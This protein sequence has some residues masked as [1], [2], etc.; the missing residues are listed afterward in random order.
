MYRILYKY[1]YNG[2]YVKYSS[3][4]PCTLPRKRQQAQA[5][6]RFYPPCGRGRLRGKLL[7]WSAEKSVEGLGGFGRGA[8]CLGQMPGLAVVGGTIAAN[9]G[10][11]QRTY[12]LLIA[13]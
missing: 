11:E 9:V 13:L 3:T 7:Q 4:P 12:F 8:V 10:F 2:T 6:P 5:C 1:P